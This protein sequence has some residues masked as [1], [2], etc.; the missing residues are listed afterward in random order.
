M[1]FPSDTGD[2]RSGLTA[3]IERSG[4]A[5]I[6]PLPLAILEP[7]PSKPQ[8]SLGAPYSDQNVKVTFSQQF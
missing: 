1:L 6:R 2:E 3:P 4:R 5:L 7:I 8:D